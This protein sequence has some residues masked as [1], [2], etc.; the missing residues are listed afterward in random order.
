MT[1]RFGFIAYP[2]GEVIDLLQLPAAR[3]EH[4]HMLHPSTAQEI[5]ER[6]A[7]PPCAVYENAENRDR[8]MDAFV[9]RH[10]GVMFC[11]FELKEGV[12]IRPSTKV[13]GFELSNRG[14]LPK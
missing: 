7:P 9:K 10:P 14:V 2:D 3:W 5:L 8:E 6:K 4:G 1:K 11:P 13:D 12:K